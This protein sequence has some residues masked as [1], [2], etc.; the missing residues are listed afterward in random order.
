MA[1]TIVWDEVSS[2]VKTKHAPK[3][4]DNIA[5][6]SPWLLRA[7]RR[8]KTWDGSE[9]LA[10]PLRVAKEGGGGQWFT[11]VDRFNLTHRN[12]ITSAIFEPKNAVIPVVVYRE[13][14]LA[15][16]GP[17]KVLDLVTAK[18]N[19]AENDIKELLS[20]HLYN[21]GTNPRAIEGLQ[22]ALKDDIASV[23]QTYGGIS[24]GGVAVASDPRGYWQH[25][26][27]V[28]GYITG[29]SSTLFPSSG[30]SPVS[31]MWARI[32][33]RSGR[34]PSLI[35]SNY[36]S[37]NDFANSR[38]PNERYNRERDIELTKSNFTNMMFRTAPWVADPFAPST[39]ANVEKIYLLDESSYHLYV[40]PQW[41]FDFENF[42]QSLDQATK[43]G[44]FFWRGQACFDER[45]S[46]GV[47]NGV[48]A[49]LTL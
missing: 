35:L 42:M 3:I 11:K 6:S 15:V 14:E 33:K 12:I 44:K 16:S 9:R 20:G 45:R 43:V 38:V 1:T 40:A 30:H 8:Q 32:A 23:A 4:K 28:T 46:S 17:D 18:M 24:C 48:D 13:E 7:Q 49:A 10:V 31:R 29:P 22:W 26:A 37:W 41:D 25:N 2:L 21:D 36:G 27:D 5:L 34:T 19:A 39:S 47:I